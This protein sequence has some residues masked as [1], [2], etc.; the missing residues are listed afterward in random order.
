MEQRVVESARVEQQEACD[1]RQLA[2]GMAA[3]VASTP[4]RREDMLSELAQHL[5]PPMAALRASAARL[6]AA[7]AESCSAAAESWQAVDRRIAELRDR[8]DR[9]DAPTSCTSC[10]ANRLTTALHV[11]SWRSS[12]VQW[13][14]CHRCC[15]LLDVGFGAMH[16]GH[17]DVLPYLGGPGAIGDVAL[18]NMT[19][20]DLDG[21]REQLARLERLVQQI[22]ELQARQID[23][24]RN[25]P[26][27]DPAELLAIDA[28]LAAVRGHD[29]EAGRAT[30]R[31]QR[32]RGARLTPGAQPVQG[33]AAAQLAQQKTRSPRVSMLR[34]S[35]IGV[36][37]WLQRG[38]A[39]RES[40]LGSDPP[41]TC[42]I[43]SAQFVQ[44]NVRSPCTTSVV[45]SVIDT[46][47]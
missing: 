22:T 38:T 40:G 47:Q 23:R 32:A 41:A 15:G 29:T 4:E 43:A 9:Y 26:G 18:G 12:A 7:A 10:G 6:E 27:M 20:P 37:Q 39:R 19:N 14:L 36:S 44:Q 8:L 42:S 1:W 33:I 25:V 28:D 35:T 2:L 46:W 31:Q 21:L 3:L 30:T 45:G 5:R 24:E 17:R 34:S 11:C 16:A 13:R